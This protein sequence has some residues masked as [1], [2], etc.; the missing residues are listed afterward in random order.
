MALAGPAAN[1]LML[2]LAALVIR[3][4]L[5]TGLM[6]PALG[7]T[8]DFSHLVETPNAPWLTGLGTFISI[9]F[10]L[11]VILCFF[12]L[13]PLPPLDGAA[14][15]T[16]FLKR[17]HSHRLMETLWNPNYAIFGLIIAWNVFNVIIGPIYRFAHNLL[18]LGTAG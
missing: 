9:L 6:V 8:L 5:F 12:N 4:G 15:P 14:I 7:K 1:F 11:N 2:L 16:L 10:S 17:H 18:F 3:V 13:L